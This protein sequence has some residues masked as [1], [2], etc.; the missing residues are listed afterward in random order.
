MQPIKRL[1]LLTSG[2]D[3]PGMNAA[4]RAVVRTAIHSGLEVYAIHEGY[5]GMV[6]GGSSIRK[7]DWNAVSGILPKGG[8]I[9]GTARSQ[10]FQ[11]S[12]A[13]RLMAAQNLINHEI[14]GLVVIGGDGSLTGANL[15]RTEWPM[16]LAQL[17]EQGAISPE[18]AAACASLYLVGLVGSIDNDM[19]GTDITIGADTALHR[20]TEAIDA[21]SSTAA[22]HQRTFVVEVMGRHCGYLALMSA[23]ATAADWVFIP[24]DPPGEN[25]EAEMGAVL[26]EGREAGRRDTIVILAEKMLDRQGQPLTVERV[27]KALAAQLDPETEVRPTVLGYVQRGGSPSAFDR[28]MSTLVGYEAVKTLLA[29]TPET[30]AQLIGM[31]NNEVVALPLMACVQ[32]TAAVASALKQQA[33]T[34]VLALRGSGFSQS[35][36][37]MKTLVRAEASRPKAQTDSPPVRLAVLNAGS[38]A[39][40]MNTATRAAVRLALDKGHL[41]LGIEDGFQGFVEGRVKELGWMDVSGWASLGGSE[42]GT[43]HKVP[44]GSDLY[45]IARTIETYKIQ[46]LLVIGGWA[47]YEAAA[48][49]FNKRADFPLFKIPLVCLPA[50]INND[51]PGSELSI[52]TDTALNNIIQVID[53]IKQS[54]VAT[55]RCFIVEVMGYYCGYLALMSGLAT[56]A[57]RV[58]LHEEGI[59]L[60]SLQDDILNLRRGLSQG[61]RLGL[62]IRN[63]KANHIYTTSFM[64]ALFEE[65]SENAFDVRQ[66]I[67]GH[68][69]EGG[70]PSPFDRIQ[71]A[72][73]AADC[74]NF[75]LEEVQKGTAG[76][77]FI[78]YQNGEITFSDLKQFQELVDLKYRRA[79]DQWW[80]KFSTIAQ[81]LDQPAP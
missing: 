23:I 17:A 81:I 43:R 45:A 30:E 28:N 55:R 8:T 6:A 62:L 79:K 34:E 21:I 12:F 15:L 69:Q 57:E 49:L 54:A 16:Y 19:E 37:L 67:L 53:K 64:R 70:D 52:G 24:E 50:T 38:P 14:N 5:K 46:G 26:R 65:E 66:A 27:C 18:K 20:I 51:L 61:K 71:A 48:T 13:K 9:I 68:L 31:H 33:Y 78:G 63:E 11:Q 76:G 60:K 32:Q 74:V 10:G 39:P 72:L 77:A 47:A 58:Y 35:Y 1:G 56:G 40:G 3:S 59:T 25:W 2:G 36:E 75:L 7:L 44:T 22:S 41:M 73:L 29:A 80:R 4:I 42:L